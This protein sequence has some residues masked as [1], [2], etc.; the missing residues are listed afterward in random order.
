MNHSEDPFRGRRR[1]GPCFI[2]RIC[3]CGAGEKR[4]GR[5]RRGQPIGGVGGRAASGASRLELHVGQADGADGNGRVRPQCARSRG[6]EPATIVCRD[7][8]LQA[9]RTRADWRA[10]FRCT[11]R[12]STTY[13]LRQQRASPLS[14]TTPNASRRSHLIRLSLFPPSC[15]RS[16]PAPNSLSAGIEPSPRLS[17]TAPTHSTPPSAPPQRELGLGLRIPPSSASAAEALPDAGRLLKHRFCTGPYR[18]R[19]EHVACPASS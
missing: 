9:R 3:Q 12:C 2:R 17:H 6:R 11:S 13:H 15:V 7:L 5:P 14:N 19:R 8:D 10:S 16:W 18:T 1:C 4:V